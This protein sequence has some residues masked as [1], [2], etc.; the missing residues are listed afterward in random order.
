LW[1]VM[2]QY[3]FKIGDHTPSAW[4]AKGVAIACYTL[5]TLCKIQTSSRLKFDLTTYQYWSFT[6]K[7]PIGYRTP[8]ASSKF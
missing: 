2:A 8:S 1:L 3:L 5:V 6:P 4:E 7:P